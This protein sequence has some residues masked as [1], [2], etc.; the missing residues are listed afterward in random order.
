MSQSL[1]LVKSHDFLQPETVPERIH[2]IGCGS[3]GSAVAEG[4]ARLG[5]TRISLYDFDRVEPKN[6]ANQMFFQQD[7]GQLKVEATSDIIRLINP[8]ASQ[9][10]RLFQ[11]GYTGQKLSGYVFLCVDNIDLRRQIVQAAQ[12]STFIRAIF[13]FRTGLTS[14]QHYAAD[15]SDPT[16]QE[17]LLNSMAF[18]HQEASEA[19][20]TSACGVTLGVAPT[21]RIIVS[22]GLANFV[23]FVKGSPLKKQILIDAFNFD[24][25]AI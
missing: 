4:L 22:Y 2:I 15:W 16:H 14:A 9:H 21:V 23:N 19:T 1:S 18:S 10:L 3:V 5:F 6:I 12:Q 11:E 25:L 17:A 7:I 13:D 24:L 20:P 8:A